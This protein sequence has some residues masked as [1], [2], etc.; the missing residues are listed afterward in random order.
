MP[1]EIRDKDKAPFEDTDYRNG[2]IGIVF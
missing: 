2:S 1:D